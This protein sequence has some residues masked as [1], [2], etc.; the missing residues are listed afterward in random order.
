MEYK[1]D[2]FDPFPDLNKSGKGRKKYSFA[3][4]YLSGIDHTNGSGSNGSGNGKSNG[5]LSNDSERNGDADRTPSEHESEDIEEWP[6]APP[7]DI[8]DSIKGYEM[9]SFDQTMCPPPLESF[10][11][12]PSASSP[13][14][15]SKDRKIPGEGVEGEV[16]TC[17]NVEGI[18]RSAAQQEEKQP[19]PPPIIIPEFES[20]LT[21]E[22]ARSALLTHISDHCCYGKAA[23]KNMHIKK[24]ECAPAYHYELQTFSEKRETAWT[25]AAIRP[26]YTD[27]M[28]GGSLGAVPPLPWEIIEHPTQ[29]FKDEFRLVQVP[30]TGSTKQCHRCRGSGGM[31][32]RDCNGKGWSRCLNCH[33]DGWMHDSGG[34]RERCFYCHHSKHGH[35]QLDCPK[36]KSGRGNIYLYLSSFIIEITSN[37]WDN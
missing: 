9:V 18:D 30:N 22:Q 31:T 19:P 10:D 24:M 29:Q 33:G 7:I 28:G 35:G 4:D 11:A 15:E 32:C 34:H 16:S 25:Y 14:Q 12:Q 5:D 13:S 17:D 6:S 37:P 26:G 23:A 8:L 36:C 21:E 2:F 1:S 27:M 3:D 20:K